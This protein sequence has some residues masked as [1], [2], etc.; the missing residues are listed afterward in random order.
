MI[1]NGQVW[2]YLE[3]WRLPVLTSRPIKE[4]AFG[5]IVLVA[6]KMNWLKNEGRRFAE[7]YVYAPI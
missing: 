6:G 1:S 7:L 3:S 5:W 4:A 2:I